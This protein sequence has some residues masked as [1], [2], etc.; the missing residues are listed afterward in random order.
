MADSVANSGVEVRCRKCGLKRRR[1]EASTDL[2][3]KGFTLIELLVVIAIIAILA[4]LILPALNRAKIAADSAGCKSNLRQLSVAMSLYVQQEAVYPVEIDP[5]IEGAGFQPYL[6]VP[7]LVNNYQLLNGGWVYLGPRSSVWACPGYNRV[8]GWLGGTNGMGWMASY[9]YDRE[10]SVYDHERLG[11]NGYYSDNYA[12][13]ATTYTKAIRE[14]EVAAPSDMIAIGDAPI[15][16]DSS[17][18]TVGGVLTP[19]ATWFDLSAFVEDRENYNAM[20]KGL[21]P[22]DSAVRAMGQRHGGRWNITFCDGHVESL[23]PSNLFTYQ[24]SSLMQRW[25]IDH[26]PHNTMGIPQ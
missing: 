12:V 2:K 24:N 16:P 18:P 17:G 20:L 25:N 1:K 22:N 5:A 9:A 7:R 26:Q 3:S 10:G 15:S 8:H 13:G 23:K 14:S 11:L 6:A 21:S 4:A 19:I